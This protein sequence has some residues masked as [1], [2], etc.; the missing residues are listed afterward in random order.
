MGLLSENLDLGF[1][2]LK[3]Y[4]MYSRG[5]THHLGKQ[6]EGELS[7]RYGFP[8]KKYE[9]RGYRDLVS[10]RITEA[11]ENM[12]ADDVLPD[13]LVSKLR[14]CGVKCDAVVMEF[15]RNYTVHGPR[16]NSVSIHLYAKKSH[17]ERYVSM[18][19]ISLIVCTPNHY[20]RHKEAFWSS[21]ERI[22]AR[23]EPARLTSIFRNKKQFTKRM[24]IRGISFDITHYVTA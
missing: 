18:G 11:F 2:K 13:R 4:Y 9:P 23:N 5:T 21:M 7:S 8:M 1:G 10:N 24:K 15:N 6:R 22:W 17:C 19:Y 14:S 16:T 3:N 20:D 12:E